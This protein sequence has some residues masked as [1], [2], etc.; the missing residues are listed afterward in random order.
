MTEVQEQ[1]D[2]NG[3]VGCQE[4][5]N[6]EFGKDTKA[7]GDCQERDNNQNNPDE[8]RLELCAVRQLIEHIV[9][10][11]GLAETNVRDHNNDPSDKS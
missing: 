6:I 7:V 5:R 4:I 10:N 1:E 3:N 8:V 2:G 11:H 9:V